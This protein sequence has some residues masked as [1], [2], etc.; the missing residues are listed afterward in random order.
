[1]RLLSTAAVWHLSLAGILLAAALTS[2]SVAGSPALRAGTD[3]DTL[4]DDALATPAKKRGPSSGADRKAESI[5]LGRRIFVHNFA[6]PE[7]WTGPEPLGE[8][9]DGLG[10]VFNEV[11]CATCHHQEG[12]GG[13]GTNEFNVEI[14]SFLLPPNLSRRDRVRQLA[15]ARDVHPGFS[16]VQRTLVLHQYALDPSDSAES[17]DQWRA[18]LVGREDLQTHRSSREAFRWTREG[19]TLQ[20]AFRQTPALWGLG[21]IDQLRQRGGDRIRAAIVSFQRNDRDGVSGRL[22]RTSSGEPG[23]FGWRGHV[24]TLQDFTRQAC[25]NELGLEVPGQVEPSHPLASPQN[26]RRAQRRDHF[27]LT[28]DQVA[29]LTS[30][31]ASLPRPV[32]V[33]PEDAH[34][35]QEIRRGEE[36]FHEVA[37]A[38]C[39][40]PNLGPLRGVFSDLLLHDLGSRSADEAAATPELVPGISLSFQPDRQGSNYS[41]P[42]IPRALPRQI[43]QTN[44]EQEWRTPALWGVA[45]SAP[46]WHD[47][48]AATLEDAIVLHEGEAEPSVNRYRA[49]PGSSKEQLRQ[50][51][52]SLRA[53]E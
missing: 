32:Q 1:M 47:G 38:T 53:P 5:S 44:H 30:F 48:R 11:S 15:A 35:V 49:L 7:S 10:P 29:A 19:V 51:L 20:T 17:Y 8:R 26:H 46:Y 50:F 27:D 43:V 28:G 37:C 39:H 31:V 18:L 6:R 41:G 9:G 52:S 23:W 33:L 24:A 3:C 16:A 2:P 34:A 14:L 40:V 45:D 21:A 36:L 22:P 25:A 12:P 42:A 13:G 4:P